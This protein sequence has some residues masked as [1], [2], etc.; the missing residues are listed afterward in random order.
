MVYGVEHLTI[1]PNDYSLRTWSRDPRSWMH[2]FRVSVERTTFPAARRDR[3]ADH[4][5]IAGGCLYSRRTQAWARGRP[6]NSLRD[7]ETDGCLSLILRRNCQV[8]AI[9]VQIE[10]FILKNLGA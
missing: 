9:S 5:D 2:A 10:N 3:G 6:K 4:R 1:F 8:I 7:H